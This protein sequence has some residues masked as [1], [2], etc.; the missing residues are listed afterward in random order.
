MASESKDGAAAADATDVDPEVED[1]ELGKRMG[2]AQKAFLLSL[3]EDVVDDRGAIVAEL[4]E[5]IEKDGMSAFYDFICREYG[6]ERD[7][8]LAGRLKAANETEVK[9]LD[10]REEDVKENHGEVEQLD[11]AVA[12]AAFYD[13][14]GDKA[15]AIELYTAAMAMKQS[16]GQKIDTALRMVRCGLFHGDLALVKERLAAAHTLVDEGGDWDRRNRL[17][18]YEAAFLLLTRDYDKAGKL[19]LSSVATFNAHEMFDYTQFVF[20][21]VLSAMK[22]LDRVEL[23]DKVVDSPDVLSAILDVPSLAEFLNALYECRYRDFFAALVELDPLLRRDRFLAPHRVWFVREMRIA[24]YAQFLESYRSVTTASMADAFGVSRD[25]M[26]G[27]LAKFIAAG[28]VSAK[29]DK[30]AGVIETNRP[31]LRNAQYQAVIQKGDVLLN[32]IQALSRTLRV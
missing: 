7:E 6:V 26:D 12:R 18:I 22:A 31:D 25:F 10:E 8:A 16:S 19:F 17:K 32:R 14:I 21:T 1:R 27:E 9:A 13:R 11:A 29:I 15:K 28:R 24:A 23:K 30:V 4:L 2:L 20:Y 5:A 3:P